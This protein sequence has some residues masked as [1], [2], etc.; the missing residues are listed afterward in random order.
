MGVGWFRPPEIGPSRAWR[1]R[2]GRLRAEVQRG[3]T[4]ESI[5]NLICTL[6]ILCGALSAR[7]KDRALEA[8]ALLLQQFMTTFGHATRIFLAILFLQT[9]KV[10]IRCE[11]FEEASGGATALLARLRAVNAAIRE[12]AA[13]PASADSGTSPEDVL[14]D[15]MNGTAEDV[16]DWGK[17]AFWNGR[18]K[19]TKGLPRWSPGAISVTTIHSSRQITSGGRTCR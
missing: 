5:D 14:D 4:V 9:L 13:P 7:D 3:R 17:K 1:A 8:S 11:E 10:Y 18:M 6:E 2:S 19:T 12:A 16:A 15:V